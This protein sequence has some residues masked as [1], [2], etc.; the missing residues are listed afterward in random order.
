MDFNTWDELVDDLKTEFQPEY[1]DYMLLSE[2]D[3]RFQGKEETFCSFLAEMQILFGKLGCPLGEHHKLYILRKNMQSSYAIAMSTIEIN[4]VRQ[5][6]TICKIIDST[7]LMQTK[8]GLTSTS[9]TR[10]LEPAFRTPLNFKKTQTVN[11]IEE[12]ETA[13][14]MI[15][16]MRFNDP[17]RNPQGERTQNKIL[18]CFKCEVPG[19]MHRDCKVQQTYYFCY[20]CGLKNVTISNCPNCNKFKHLN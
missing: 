10:F 13:E 9:Q 2:I 11:E 7:K 17:N 6:A 15:E 4:S 19:H 20:A 18:K 8:Q 12:S 16:A 5:L 14:M 3:S 1:Y